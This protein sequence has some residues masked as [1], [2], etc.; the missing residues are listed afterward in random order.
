MTDA[1]EI[2]VEEINTIAQALWAAHEV[3]VM[4]VSERQNWDEMT[5]L[6]KER[7]V[8]SAVIVGPGLVRT[9]IQH[10]L[11]S[12]SVSVERE[13]ET[14]RLDICASCGQPFRSCKCFNAPDTPQS[15]PAC[16]CSKHPL[17][18]GY[19]GDCP[20][21]GWFEP[22]APDTLQSVPPEDDDDMIPNFNDLARP[23][24]DAPLS[25]GEELYGDDEEG[26][27]RVVSLIAERDKLKEEAHY[28]N[29]VADLAIKHRDEA[30]AERD[31]LKEEW[32]HAAN[33]I[34][35]YHADMFKLVERVSVLEGALEQYANMEKEGDPP[36]WR[37][38]P[39]LARAALRT[40][41][42]AK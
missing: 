21:H 29:G 23:T 28:A 42:D 25:Q 18:D 40:S 22:V 31:K 4:P 16:T 19:D 1:R 34:K 33:I 2:A 26:R 30:E 27:N 37:G 15:V 8:K 12:P 36:C 39:Y 10:R 35:G 6:E 14:Q 41:E 3:W 5:P 17:W 7:W 11:H 38:T 24:P 32:E 9:L 20:I 13:R